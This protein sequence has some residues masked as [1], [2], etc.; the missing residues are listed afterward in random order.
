M[1]MMSEY[2]HQESPFLGPAR[3]SKR[4]LTSAGEDFIFH[5]FQRNVL[6]IFDSCGNT[7]GYFAIARVEHPAN[8]LPSPDRACF[9]DSGSPD[10]RPHASSRARSQCR[11]RS[12]NT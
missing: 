12:A 1:K 10:S 8:E 9:H 11:A 7:W 5:D 6:P 3:L 2:S 4:K